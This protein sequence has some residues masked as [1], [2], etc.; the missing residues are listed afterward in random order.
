MDRSLCL[1]IICGL[2][3][4]A[5]DFQ[6]VDEDRK[7]GG[8][9]A[10]SDLHNAGP[11]TM[12]NQQ[13]LKADIDL[14]NAGSPWKLTPALKVLVDV[15]T[16]CFSRLPFTA[17]LPPVFHHPPSPFPFSAQFQKCFHVVVFY[18]YALSMLLNVDSSQR[19]PLSSSS[20]LLC[21]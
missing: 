7:L 14:H 8:R 18:L 9:A 11:L 10:D 5:K 3:E 21:G 15:V 2:V 1:S 6:N 20:L 4:E 19:T 12:D 17:V 13:G 16:S